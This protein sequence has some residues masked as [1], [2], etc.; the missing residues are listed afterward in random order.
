MAVEHLVA[1]G[2]A[3]NRYDD[4]KHGFDDRTI[5]GQFTVVEDRKML[6]NNSEDL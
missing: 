4:E 1:A 3:K 6:T 2:A 5:E